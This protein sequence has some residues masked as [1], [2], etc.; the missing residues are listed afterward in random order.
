MRF[1]E[2]SSASHLASES[3]EAPDQGH[4]ADVAGMSQHTAHIGHCSQYVMERC[5]L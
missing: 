4:V 1:K 2:M 3:W 5:L